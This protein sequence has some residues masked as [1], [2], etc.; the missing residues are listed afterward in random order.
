MA[1]A[2]IQK[3]KRDRNAREERGDP[4]QAAVCF[5]CFAEGKATLSF[6]CHV[7][8]DPVSTER[9]GYAGATAFESS[10]RQSR[11]QQKP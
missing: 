2:R 9:Q 8:T 10:P 7:T 6:R 11:S 4:G 3:A 1:L 5:T